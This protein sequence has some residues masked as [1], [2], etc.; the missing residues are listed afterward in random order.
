MN[1]HEREEREMS[2]ERK[3][4]L[5]SKLDVLDSARIAIGRAIDELDSGDRW[6]D[7]DTKDAIFKLEAIRQDLEDQYMLIE[8][9]LRQIEA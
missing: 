2:N 5:D 8:D 9:E 4:V 3:M 1:H 6:C 7:L